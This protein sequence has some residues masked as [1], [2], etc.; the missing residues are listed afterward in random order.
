MTHTR[1]Y[2]I[3][4]GGHVHTDWWSGPMREATHGSNKG[5][6]FTLGEWETVRSALETFPDIFELIDRTSDP[7][8]KNS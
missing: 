7:T 8:A 4:A 6:T 2:F 3:V 5:L 1:I